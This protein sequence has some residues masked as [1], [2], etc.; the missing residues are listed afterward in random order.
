MIHREHCLQ[1]SG[2]GK[3]MVMSVVVHVAQSCIAVQWNTKDGPG[4]GSVECVDKDAVGNFT[5]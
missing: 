4:N 1:Q 3:C 2:S 5:I